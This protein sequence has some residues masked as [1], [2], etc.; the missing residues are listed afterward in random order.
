M[1]AAETRDLYDI[2]VQVCDKPED[3]YR[4]AHIIAALT[5]SAV[6]VTDGACLEN[7]QHLVNI[8][9]GGVPDQRTLDRVD[10]YFRFGS[11]PAPVGRPELGLADEYLSWEARGDPQAVKEPSR[12]GHGIVLPDRMV[13]FADLLADPAKGRT[14][15]AQI[16]Y[17]ERGNLQGAQ[18]YPLAGRVYELARERGLGIE[19]P[20]EWFVQDIR[21]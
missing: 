18:F 1:F 12:R 10:V 13:S 19:V 3:I 11:T 21:D 8:G 4:G 9:A 17:S 20:T 5:D 7:G 14:S 6:P 2:E 15:S 16:T